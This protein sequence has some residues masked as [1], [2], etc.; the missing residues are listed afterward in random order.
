MLDIAI[1]DDELAERER[2]KACL[3]YVEEQEG[4]SFSVQEYESADQFLMMFEQQY[5]IVFMDIQ[6]AG[7]MDGM[8]AARRLR[9][10]DPSVLLIFVTN[11]AQMALHGYEVDALDFVV[12]PLDPYAFH[13]K[14]Q[15]AL[16]RVSSR[17]KS[18]IEVRDKG[19]TVYLDTH[20]IRYLEVNG[21]YVIYHTR[22]GSYTE[23]ISMAAAEKKLNDPAFFRCD[24][25]LIINMRMLTKIEG[26]TC[27]VDGETLIVAHILRNELK[28][29][30]AN[31]LSGTQRA[32]EL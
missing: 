29:A 6:F 7:G 5:D 22:G 25:G 3:A 16:G 14:M 18:T 17:K 28:R 12:K 10:A 32:K 26:D 24:R 9:K 2:L 30:L 13:L 15:R 27:V 21:H 11:L 19:S 1:V 8:S 20:R 31:Y 23:Y 4:V